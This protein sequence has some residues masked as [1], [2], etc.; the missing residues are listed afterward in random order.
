MTGTVKV[1]KEFVISSFST[2]GTLSQYSSA[3]TDIGLWES[4]K[5]FFGKHL[6][7]RHYSDC[8]RMISGRK[9]QRLWRSVL[10]KDIAV[11]H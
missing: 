5:V 1:N 4:E 8:L 11:I 7:L 2:E 9:K 10:H 6:P 3:V